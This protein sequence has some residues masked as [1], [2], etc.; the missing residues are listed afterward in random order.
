MSQPVTA[1][2]NIQDIRLLSSHFDI[3]RTFVPGP[4]VKVDVKITIHHNWDLEKKLLQVSV[5]VDVSGDETPFNLMVECGGVFQLES[6]PERQE[7]LVW[8]AEINCAAI[9]FPFVRETVAEIT[10]KAG[11]GPMLMQPIN[12]VELYNTNHP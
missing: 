10:R 2:F 8:T 9:L 5:I 1:A 7:D 11:I 12:F 6:V 3:N 4:D